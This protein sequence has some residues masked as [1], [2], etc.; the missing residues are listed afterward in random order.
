[1]DPRTTVDILKI[2]RG[3]RNGF[4][5]GAKVRMMHSVVI[6][7]LFMKGSIRQRVKRIIKLTLEHGLRIGAFVLIYKTVLTVLKRTL[8]KQRPIHSLYGGALGSIAIIYGGETAINQQ[9]TFYIL[10][11]V[12]IAAIKSMQD[13]GIMANVNSNR[14]L[15]VIG[16]GWVMYLFCID[17]KSLQPSL[18]NSMSLLYTESDNV[19]CWTELVPFPVPE[20]MK[21]WFEG[22]FPGLKN[23]KT[24]PVKYQEYR[25]FRHDFEGRGL[26]IGGAATHQH[27]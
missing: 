6:S 23:I 26:P 5:Y 9:I 1:M 13:A 10:S 21:M 25:G 15:S 22:T 17:S 12:V 11:R 7:I 16:W 20:F 18:Q 4:Y 2:I 3:A 27:Q 8:G 19:N 14:W 24:T